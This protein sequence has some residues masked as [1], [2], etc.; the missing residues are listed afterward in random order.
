MI[1]P[2][3]RCKRMATGNYESPFQVH[4]ETHGIGVFSTPVRQSPGLIPLSPLRLL[5]EFFLTR[6][7]SR[8]WFIVVDRTLCNRREFTR[9]LSHRFLSL[10]QRACNP[11]AP[12]PSCINPLATCIAVGGVILLGERALPLRSMRALEGRDGSPSRG[13]KCEKRV[14]DRLSGSRPQ[15]VL[16]RLVHRLVLPSNCFAG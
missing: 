10:M 11:L 3:L 2:S 15:T 16:L 8:S 1:L 7:P 5:P 4:T 9:L 6:Q 14:S 12:R 13:G